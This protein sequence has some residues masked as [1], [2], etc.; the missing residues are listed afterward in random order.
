MSESVSLAE[1]DLLQLPIPLAVV[2]A[3]RR[4]QGCT[5]AFAQILGKA[6]AAFAGQALAA[7]GMADSVCGEQAVRVESGVAVPLLVQPWNGAWLIVPAPAARAGSRELLSV[8]AGQL[9]ACDLNLPALD[10]MLSDHS[11]LPSIKAGLG[12]LSEA[13]RQAVLLVRQ[14]AAEVPKLNAGSAQVGASSE[15]QDAA[16][17][18]ALGSAAALREGLKAAAD[19]LDA[20]RGMAD[21]AGALAGNGTRIADAFNRTMQEVQDSTKRADAIVQT[22]D[23]VVM[24]TNILSINAGIEAARA[25]D[26]GR[27]FGVVAR[28][29]RALSER[30]AGAARDVRATLGEIH[31][32]IAEGLRQ[33][34]ETGSALASVVELM[35]RAGGA[36]R[37]GASRV[38]ARSSDVVALE[39]LM[40]GV[41]A[42]AAHNLDA[43]A[44][45]LQVSTRMAGQIGILDD[46][47]G[48]F[49]LSGDPL[50]E[51]RHARALE[52]ARTAS[53]EAGKA[54][55]SLLLKRSLSEESLFT[56]DYIPIART[57]PPKHSTA[58]D[59]R[60]DEVLPAVQEPVLAAAPWAVYAICANRDGYVPTHNHRFCQPLTGDP[61]LDLA[62]NRT[63]RIF[64]DRVGRSVGAHTEPYLLQVYRRDT[65]QIMFDISVPIRV[66]GRHWGG[67]RIGYALT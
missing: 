59:G 64:S 67:F 57:D 4:V 2:T 11:S 47:V 24:Q 37:D 19:A 23:A 42:E 25:G 61:K 8:L 43:V 27:G 38:L 45:M 50:S 17:A 10:P 62:H 7:L 12:N 32:R 36:M 18:E 1:L 16:L 33:A 22:I 3:D 28:E 60:C 63:K 26:A 41:S 15:S 65:G 54:L 52:L 31:Q 14:V 51:P 20:V 40:L 21:E 30:T 9:Q 53:A 56:T 29:I 66:G 55:E 49:R 6:P 48:L 35:G 39:Q 13:L 34:G 44:S 58:F 5:P 46:C